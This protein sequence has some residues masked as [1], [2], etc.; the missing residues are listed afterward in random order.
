MKPKRS[1]AAPKSDAA[2]RKA[3]QSAGKLHGKGFRQLV[4]E[5]KAAKGDTTKMMNK[6]IKRLQGQKMIGREDAEQLRDIASSLGSKATVK[7]K[8]R[9]V[10]SIYKHMLARPDTRP[11][12]VAIGS[13]AVDSLGSSANAA[14]SGSSGG[15]GV[16]SSDVNGALVGGVV[17][18]TL[19][20]VV[21]AVLGAGVGMG[22]GAVIGALSGAA[23]G[24]LA[25]SAN[26]QQK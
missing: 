10:Q 3:A 2:L 25:A 5:A 1:S 9:L 16:S 4:R 24:G 20:A 14:S 7:E 26:Q 11:V 19:G 8:L 21:G 12:A 6:G 22:P 13:I 17:G 18:G 23:A 15:S